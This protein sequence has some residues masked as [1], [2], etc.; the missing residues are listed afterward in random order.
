MKINIKAPGSTLREAHSENFLLFKIWM[1]SRPTG[2]TTVGKELLSWFP[3]ELD[4][5]HSSLRTYI[6]RRLEIIIYLKITNSFIL[7]RI[8]HLTWKHYGRLKR[9]CFPFKQCW[10][11]YIS[12]CNDAISFIL[13]NII[14]TISLPRGI[15]Q[16]IMGKD[17]KASGCVSVQLWMENGNMEFPNRII[18]ILQ[19]F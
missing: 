14:I 15:K 4:Y 13:C 8:L 19:I 3:S 16:A 17:L 9:H 2:Y 6:H 12:V 1:H 10:N 11:V 18:F 7:T 5:A